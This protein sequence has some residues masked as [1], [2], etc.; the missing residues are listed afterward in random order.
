MSASSEKKKSFRAI[1]HQLNPAVTIAANGR[2]EPV[3]AELERAL[4]DHELIK[5]K[6]AINDREARKQILADIC[7]QCRTEVIQQIGKVALIY[8]EN[9]QASER[10]SNLKRIV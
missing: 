4:T 9:P 10:L 3:M 6:M 1:G 8:R 2:S 5:I 7:E